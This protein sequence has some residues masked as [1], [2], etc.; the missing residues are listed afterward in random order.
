MSSSSSISISTSAGVGASK[1]SCG[2]WVWDC[3]CGCGSGLGVAQLSRSTSSPLETDDR[4]VSTSASSVVDVRRGLALGESIIRGVP[5]S[6]VSTPVTMYSLYLAHWLCD[7]LL[8]RISCSVLS[9]SISSASIRLKM[10]MVNRSFALSGRPHL[11]GWVAA[12]LDFLRAFFDRVLFVLDPTPGLAPPAFGCSDALT[13]GFVGD[14]SDDGWLS[15][16][17]LARVGRGGV[18]GIEMWS[19]P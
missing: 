11:E 17:D 1:C 7:A 16:C 12:A 9:G 10:R 5:N 14:L 3:S 19:W 6:S 15:L 4:G 2:C 18:G 8:I 13:Y